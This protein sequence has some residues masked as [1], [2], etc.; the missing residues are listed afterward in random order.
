MCELS[1]SL[2]ERNGYASEDL[3]LAVPHQANLRIICAMQQRL[4]IDD[5]K[6]LVNID[7]YGN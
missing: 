2:L 6:V 4:G 3:A 1:T 5:S 7:R